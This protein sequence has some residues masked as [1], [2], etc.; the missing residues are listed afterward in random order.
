MGLNIVP[1][2]KDQRHHLEVLE[3]AL[4]NSI[5]LASRKDLPAK[6]RL[7]AVQLR[8]ECRRALRAYEREVG[9]RP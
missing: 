1:L 8:M 6:V 5:D 2:T 4:R 9:L 3:A 7:R